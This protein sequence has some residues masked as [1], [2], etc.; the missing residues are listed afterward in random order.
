MLC[1]S[2]TRQP[3]RETPPPVAMAEVIICWPVRRFFYLVQRLSRQAEAGRVAVRWLKE[4]ADGRW[5]ESG[6]VW[7]EDE[8]ALMRVRTQTL[9]SEGG[10]C[11]KLLTMRSKIIGVDLED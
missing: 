10:K 5:H 4:H 7:T 8:G 9:E 2:D 11:Y 1:W 6:K 3:G